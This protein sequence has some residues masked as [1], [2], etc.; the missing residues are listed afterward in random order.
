MLRSVPY[1]L[2]NNGEDIRNDVRSGGVLTGI[3]QWRVIAS[4]KDLNNAYKII[5]I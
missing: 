4:A 3:T 1:R 5:C 2:V